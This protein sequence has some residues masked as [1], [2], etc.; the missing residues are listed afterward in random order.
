MKITEF[1]WDENNLSHLFE[2]GHSVDPLEIEEAFAPDN[3]FKVKKVKDRYHAYAETN[4]GRYLHII[5]EYRGRGIARPISAW[6]MPGKE[7]RKFKK[8]RR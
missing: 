4:A 3:L 7:K 6:D 8:I 1:E 5:F 2:S